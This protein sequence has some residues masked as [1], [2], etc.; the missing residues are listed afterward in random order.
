[1]D[2]KH[3]AKA[4]RRTVLARSIAIAPNTKM[5]PILNLIGAQQL[6]HPVNAQ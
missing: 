3:P 2:R 6:R 1:L 5:H 4:L